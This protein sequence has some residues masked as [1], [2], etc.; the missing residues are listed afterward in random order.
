MSGN[1]S[2]DASLAS[3]A[4]SESTTLVLAPSKVSG[5]GA[6]HL[7]SKPCSLL[8]MTSGLIEKKNNYLLNS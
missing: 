8:R 6:T 3:Q 4:A 2:V 1:S 5:V 7:G